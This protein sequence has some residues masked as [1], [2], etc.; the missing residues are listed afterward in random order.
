MLGSAQATISGNT[1]SGNKG[2]GIY[3]WGLAPLYILPPTA[4]IQG[5]TISGNEGDGILMRGSAQATI[6]GNKITEN[7]SYGVALD[8]L[9]CVDVSLGFTGAVRG[10]VNEIL[11][12]KEGEVCPAELEFLM[13]EAGG[14]Y[15][16]KC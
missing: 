6:E 1:I 7:A 5:N 9:P 15:G 16:P 10:R 12:N 3:M 8:Q 14:C 4:S 2:D 13:T 11:G